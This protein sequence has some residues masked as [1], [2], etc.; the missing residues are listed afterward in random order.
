MLTRSILL[1]NNRKIDFLFIDGSHD[2]EDVLMDWLN[3]RDLVNQKGII[4]FHDIVGEP[5]VATVWKEINTNLSDG[6]LT[7]EINNKGIPLLPSVNMEKEL[8]LGYKFREELPQE[9]RKFIS[10]AQEGN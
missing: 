4:C 7:A 1:N 8:G 3:Y 10:K 6:Y 2:E 5:E 9:L